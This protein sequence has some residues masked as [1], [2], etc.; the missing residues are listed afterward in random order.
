MFPNTWANGKKKTGWS[1]Y[2]HL[3]GPSFYWRARLSDLHANNGVDEEKHGDEE[4]NVWESFEGLDEGPK[5]NPDRVALSQQLDQTGC[6]EQLQEAHVE[7]ID[8]L[9]QRAKK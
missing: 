4:A 9:G 5:E 1:G 2:G 3:Q 6:S 7:L 8:R